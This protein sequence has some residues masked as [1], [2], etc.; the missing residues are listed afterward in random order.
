MKSDNEAE[1]IKAAANGDQSAFSELVTEYERLV[2]NTVK[3]KVLSAEDAMDISQ[4]VFIKIWKALQRMSY[5]KEGA[6]HRGQ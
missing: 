1:L 2:Y 4:E 5:V 3:S 6:C